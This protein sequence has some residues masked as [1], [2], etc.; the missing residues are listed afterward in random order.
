[1]RGADVVCL[2]TSAS[3][4]VIRRDWLA[5]GTHVTSVGYAP[6]G[7]ELDPQAI[8]LGH[9]F[10]ETRLAFEPPPLGC[11]ELAGL[12]PSGGAELGEILLGQRP[13]RQSDNEI[14]AL[15]REVERI[16]A[17]CRSAGYKVSRL[18]H[19]RVPLS[20]RLTPT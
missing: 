4:P 3:E 20:P 19:L 9:L 14:I 18:R 13:G 16:Q 7:G 1:V 17:D 12:D 6:P 10:V 15:R 5:P 11:A 2:C 8:E